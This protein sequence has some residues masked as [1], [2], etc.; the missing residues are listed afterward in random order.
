MN[1]QKRNKMIGKSLL[2]FLVC[3][4]IFLCGHVIYS[5]IR[6]RKANALWLEGRHEEAVEIYYATIT[7]GATSENQGVIYGRMIDYELSRNNPSGAQ[8]VLQLR[9]EWGGT[10]NVFEGIPLPVC[11]TEQGKAMVKGLTR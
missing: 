7:I 1:K 9:K 11:E 2:V 5:H 8:K 10:G 6:I 4:L 3:W